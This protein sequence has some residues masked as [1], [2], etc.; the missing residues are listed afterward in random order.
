MS[1]QYFKS[2]HS[3]YL[4]HVHMVFVTKYRSK[5]F[6]ENHLSYFS[7][8]AKHICEESG[9]ELL[10]CNGESDHVHMLISYPPTMQLSV[11]VN[12]LKA[13]SSRRMRNEFAD[14]RAA[15]KKP[16]L[17]SRAYFVCSCGGASLDVVKKYIQNQQG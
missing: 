1:V 7:D 16:V 17:W 15:Y 6:G 5:I 9:S 10:E 2:R 11:L 12:N 4:L 13:V 8:I 14:L 3:A